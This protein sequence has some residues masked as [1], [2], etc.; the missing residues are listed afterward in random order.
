MTDWTCSM[1][2]RLASRGPAVRR[3]DAN[4]AGTTLLIACALVLCGFIALTTYGCGATPPQAAMNQLGNRIE[5]GR[6]TST[7]AFAHP[8]PDRAG[9]HSPYAIAAGAGGIWFTEYSAPMLGLI[10]PGG[11]FKQ[12]DLD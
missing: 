11:A 1:D 5:A 3:I 10:A 7:P 4:S 6:A 12:A 8:P 9:I 2:H